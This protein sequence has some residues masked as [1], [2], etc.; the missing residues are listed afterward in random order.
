M[1]KLKIIDLMKN[2]EVGEIGD[3]FCDYNEG[4]LC[5]IITEISDN[6]VDIYNCDLIEWAKYNIDYIDE[7]MQEF[8]TPDDFLQIIKQGQYYKNEKNLYDNLGDNL[9]N[10]A[11]NYILNIL[12]IDEITEEQNEKLLNFDYTDN[13]EQ[14]ENIIEHIKSIFEKGE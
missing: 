9:K 14:L 11:Y 10:F 2:L 8:G 4:Y 1:K 3:N 7:A 6:H 5:D 13:N 12:K